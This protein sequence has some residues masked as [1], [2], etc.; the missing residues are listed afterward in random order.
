MIVTTFSN[1]IFTCSIAVP[2]SHI[3]LVFY[4]HIH[5]NTACRGSFN[6]FLSARYSWWGSFIAKSRLYPNNV[7]MKDCNANVFLKNFRQCFDR[8]FVNS[9]FFHIEIN[10]IFVKKREK[11]FFL[12]RQK[13]NPKNNWSFKALTLTATTSA[14]PNKYLLADKDQQD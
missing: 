14:D 5:K 2:F 3:T 6:H 13:G 11:R 12:S 10:M 9:G 8:I 1:P 7:T 4:V